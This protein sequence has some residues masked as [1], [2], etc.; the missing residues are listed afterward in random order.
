MRRLPE[1][2]PS[3]TS[4]QLFSF[5]MI[6]DPSA[7]PDEDTQRQ[8]RR[9]AANSWRGI[10][11]VRNSRRAGLRLLE[12]KV[13]EQSPI[14]S[15]DILVSALAISQ[16]HGGN[17]S[18]RHPSRKTQSVASSAVSLTQSSPT[19][20]PSPVTLL[21]GGRMDPF[22]SCAVHCNTMESFLLDHCK[23]AFY[24]FEACRNG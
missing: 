24:F 6:S 4:N 10:S 1:S 17:S 13:H 8:V 2:P 22:E 9:H 12:P 19:P 11:R 21:G 7:G 18:E 3:E 16:T 14:Q 20:G 5:V 15:E 23:F